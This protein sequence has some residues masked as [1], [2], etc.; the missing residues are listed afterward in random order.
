MKE[1]T[2]GLR[3]REWERR[4][5]STQ[6]TPHVAEDSVVQNKNSINHEGLRSHVGTSPAK[7]ADDTSC[8]GRL[9][10]SEQKLNQSRR[11]AFPRHTCVD[12]TGQTHESKRECRQEHIKRPQRPSKLWL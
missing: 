8:S 1:R 4:L 6:M 9:G 11:A 12:V 2:N 7:Y 5:R 10:C 3:Q